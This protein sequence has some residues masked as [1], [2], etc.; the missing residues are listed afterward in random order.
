MIARTIFIDQI[1][2][3]ELAAGIP[4][5]VFLGAGYDSRAYRFSSELGS[6]RLYE[7]DIATTQGRK[8]DLLAK[9]GIVIPP[10]LTF[11]PIDF[12]SQSLAGTLEQAGFSPDLMTLFV[13]EG[14]MYYLPAPAVEATLDFIRSHAKTG[15]S[16]VFDYLNEKRESGNT[17]EPFH[18]YKSGPEMEAFLAGRGFSIHEHLGQAEIEK[19]FLTLKGGSSAWPSVSY[20]GMI[21]AVVQ[22]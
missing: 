16:V 19:R 14:V 2:K 11:V 3:Q 4:Q 15:S 9:A 10:Q 20:L 17:G 12:R 1:V 13:W 22:S 6:C 8:K 5:I 7:L 18:F 21:Q